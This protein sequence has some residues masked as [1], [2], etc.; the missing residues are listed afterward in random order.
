MPKNGDFYKENLIRYRTISLLDAQNRLIWPTGNHIIVKKWIYFWNLH[1]L[2]QQCNQLHNNI[3][4][5]FPENSCTEHLKLYYT[6]LNTFVYVSSKKKFLK[7]KITSNYISRRKNWNI[8]GNFII[9]HYLLVYLQQR[10]IF[11]QVQFGSFQN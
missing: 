7:F 6:Y 4:V 1:H 9:L 10:D 11:A 3:Q 8:N 5:R 2:K